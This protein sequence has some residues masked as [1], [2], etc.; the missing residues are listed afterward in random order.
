[1]SSLAT[2]LRASPWARALSPADLARVE[3]ETVTRICPP[4][5]L[6]CRK[7]ETVEAWIGVVVGLV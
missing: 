4:G 5:S 2:H 1:M 6:V 7:G 3:A